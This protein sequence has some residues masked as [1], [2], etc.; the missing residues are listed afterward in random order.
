MVLINSERRRGIVALQIH[1]P[2]LIKQAARD[3]QNAK[4]RFYSSNLSEIRADICVCTHEKRHEYA[5]FVALK[6]ETSNT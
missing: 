6:E 2:V 4:K 5:A 1:M 3:M